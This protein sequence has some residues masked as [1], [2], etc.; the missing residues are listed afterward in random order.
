MKST[1]VAP[2]TSGRAE[3]LARS[4]A[5]IPP[6]SKRTSPPTI[7][8]A[9]RLVCAST[10]AARLTTNIANVRAKAVST[11]RLDERLGLRRRPS[12]TRKSSCPS[13]G[14]TIRARPRYGRSVPRVTY[15]AT[16]KIRRTGARAIRTAKSAPRR[17]WRIPACPE[18]PARPAKRRRLERPRAVRRNDRA[19]WYS[20]AVSK[21]LMTLSAST[22]RI[23]DARRTSGYATKNA[24]RI[25]AM[26]VTAMAERDTEISFKGM[27]PLPGK[28]AL[29]KPRKTRLKTTERAK[30]Q[31]AATAPIDKAST[32]SPR[33]EERRVGKECRSRRWQ[34]ATK[35]T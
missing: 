28:D 17:N 31:S 22:T 34:D 9:T 23:F 15:R 10:M 26:I 30:P 7:V 6:E 11:A 5:V 13:Q 19:S 32:R 4:P 33:S 24:A 12:A 18:L 8:R 1:T 20:T 35:E 21:G 2:L 16:P 27:D 14:R 3:R 29:T 25:A